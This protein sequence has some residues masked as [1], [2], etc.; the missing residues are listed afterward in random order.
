MSTLI[1]N[2]NERKPKK[3]EFLM[4]HFFE[5]L[6]KISFSK[7]II[8]LRNRRA[9]MT[10]HL[11]SLSLGTTITHKGF[12]SNSNKGRFIPTRKFFTQNGIYPK[13]KP[14]KN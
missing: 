13:N 4:L 12:A 14:N 3:R 10:I 8:N 2:R 1:Y 5:H 7:K 9:R 11:P 6:R